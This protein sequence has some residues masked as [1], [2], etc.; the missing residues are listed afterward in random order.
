[1]MAGEW[2]SGTVPH[3]FADRALKAGNE[4]LADHM[5]RAATYMVRLQRDPQ[6]LLQ[7]MDAVLSSAAK[8]SADLSKEDYAALNV[9]F[10]QLKQAVANFRNRGG[11]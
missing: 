9:D 3:Q 8:T 11:S 6:P 4:E 7:A 10:A 2:L 5:G 1:M